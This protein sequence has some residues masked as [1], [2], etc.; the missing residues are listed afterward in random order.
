MIEYFNLDK[1]L[2]KMKKTEEFSPNCWINVSNPNSEEIDFLEN[3]FKLK[4]ENIIDGLD[5]HEN[6]RF[7]IESKKIY[8]Y[9]TA[10]TNKI[11]Q[12][13]DSSFLIVYSKD[14]FLT[15]SKHN[16]EIFDAVLSDKREN[17]LFSKSRNLVKV[18]Y[19]LSRF[20][21]KSVHKIIKDTK[22]NKADLNK[23]TNKDIEKLINDEDKLTI[24]ISSFGSTINTYK[25]ILRDKSLTFLKKDEE[26][27]EDLIIDLTESLELC[28]QTLKSISNMRNY[29]TTKLSNNLNKSVN[30]L[31]LFTIFL[32][33]PTLISSIYGMNVALPMQSNSKIIF[34][35]AL[36]VLGIWVVMFFILKKIKMI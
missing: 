7:E 25:R 13:Y 10:P 6:P 27:I 20:F 1:K 8:I 32:S 30:I 16:L 4:K 5:I 3:K 35:L 12:E 29:Y 14:F 9:L 19:S 21:E 24:Y 31:T 22:E 28:K 33:I 17:E 2:K 15:L 23:L 26:L 36:L 11:K 34:L 18:L